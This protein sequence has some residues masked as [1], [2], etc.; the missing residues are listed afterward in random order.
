MVSPQLVLL[1]NFNVEANVNV[2]ANG[3]VNFHQIFFLLLAEK[4]TT[5]YNLQQSEAY[6]LQ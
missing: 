6:F 5:S 1:V 3:N 4:I 2:N